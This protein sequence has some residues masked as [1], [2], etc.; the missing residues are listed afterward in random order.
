M[1]AHE[2]IIEAG[3][4]QMVARRISA[5]RVSTV[6][7]SAPW[8]QAAMQQARQRK[9]SFNELATDKEKFDFLYKLKT[10]KTTNT[11][12]IQGP[13]ASSYGA[14]IV[15]NIENYNPA[16]G[17]IE[18]VGYARQ[19]RAGSQEL[20]YRANTN[21]F[22]YSSRF[23]KGISTAGYDYFFTPGSSLELISQQARVKPQEPVSKAVA[24]PASPW[25]ILDKKK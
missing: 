17:D 21:T 12:K 8:V 10:G 20:K 22:N 2:F 14:P 24:K 23:R 9:K 4:P 16:T 19:G 6:D 3:N 18:L 5:P 1:R 25:D 11:I 15:L 7:T 13:A